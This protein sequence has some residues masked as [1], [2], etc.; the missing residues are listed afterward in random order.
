MKKGS[1]RGNPD[2]FHGVRDVS[3]SENEYM[4]MYES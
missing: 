3:D 4:L 2:E 1:N